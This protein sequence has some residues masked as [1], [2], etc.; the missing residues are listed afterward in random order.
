MNIITGRTGHPHVTSQQQRDTYAA[1]FGETD[2]VLNVGRRL[3]AEHIG[4]NVV[5]V[6]DGQISMQGCTASV[7][8]GEYEDIQ[9]VAGT[10]GSIR[11]DLLVA[12]YRKTTEDYE[13]VESVEL[14]A[15]YN[16]MTDVY[17]DEVYGY[18][19]NS[20]QIENE[21][22]IRDGAT[23]YTMPL[24]EVVFDGV[25]VSE[26]NPLFT[27]EEWNPV[28]LSSNFINS[29]EDRMLKYRRKGNLVEITGAIRTT[30]ELAVGEWQVGT[31]DDESS[32]PDISFETVCQ[33]TATAVF[34]L[35]VQAS[36]EMIVS[37]YRTGGSSSFEKIP[38]NAWL[39][40]H[41]IYTVE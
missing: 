41:A 15:I 6:Y 25:T 13:T 23:E 19:K 16:P 21:L 4:N 2:K 36:G 29:T 30:S 27:L 20:I 1:I 17:V 32:R 12:K 31:I 34:M 10:I 39:S 8:V 14:A 40:I 38:N 35:R 24:Y 33:G 5:R 11:R 9:F 18:S 28:V 7:D 37:R 22:S 26:I 3:E